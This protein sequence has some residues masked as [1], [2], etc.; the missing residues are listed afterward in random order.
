M[1]ILVIY[2]KNSEEDAI[3]EN[4]PVH[5]TRREYLVMLNQMPLLENP[6]NIALAH[7]QTNTGNNHLCLLSS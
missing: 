6:I 2:H 3:Q 5:Y 4:T 7:T 1:V